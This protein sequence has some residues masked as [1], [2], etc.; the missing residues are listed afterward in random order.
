MMRQINNPCFQ[1]GSAQ[2]RVIET[3][4]QAVAQESL[5]CQL[6]SLYQHLTDRK[7]LMGRDL[8]RLV[9]TNLNFI[10]ITEATNLVASATLVVV[11]T[12][13]RTKGHVED[14]VV[15]QRYRNKGLGKE[16]VGEVI[17]LGQLRGCHCLQLTSKPG[18][19]GTR[20]FYPQLGFELIANAR[21]G[22]PEGTNLY[23]YEF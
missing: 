21:E 10:L 11:K 12:A 17:R 16:I 20:C 2:V 6:T 13:T 18:R 23:R 15:D 3:R 1:S 4:E 14:V 19:R 9:G 7:P 8:I 22:H 5:F